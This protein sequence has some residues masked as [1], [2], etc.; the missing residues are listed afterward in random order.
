LLV[1]PKPSRD[2]VDLRLIMPL[3]YLATAAVGAVLGML[4]QDALAFLVKLISH[5]PDI[6]I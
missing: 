1:A 3:K 4:A 6:P 2:L 5:A